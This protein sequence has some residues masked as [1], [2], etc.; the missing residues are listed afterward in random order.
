[1]KGAR[2]AV[3]DALTG[4]R[5]ENLVER[6]W[7]KDPSVWRAAPEQAG[8]IRDRLGWLTVYD[9][10]ASEATALRAFA[11]E[12]GSAGFGRAM[13]LGMGGSSLSAEVCR[14]VLGIAPGFV[15]VS[16]LDT[17]DPSAIARC[18]RACDP[19]RTL[20][21][22]ASKSGTT[23]ESCYLH[24][25]FFDRM[26]AL[27]GHPPGDHFVAITDPGT[28]LAQRAAEQGFRKVFLNPPDIGG[29]YSALSYFGMLP[30]ALMGADLDALLGGAAQMAAACRRSAPLEENPGAALGVTL[31][32]LAARGR[33]KLTLVLPE[34][35]AALGT[36]LE[37]L[38]AES[39][40]KE[41]RGI[42]PVDGEPIGLPGVYGADRVFVQLGEN[43]SAAEALRQLEAAGHPVVR[44]GA[45]NLGGEFFRWEFA[46]AVA[47]AILGVNP[48]DEPNVRESK[49]NTEQ[50]LE[51]F[52]ATG[53]LGAP[54]PASIGDLVPFLRQARPGDYVA[55]LA[56]VD[57]CAESA[58]A[59]GRIRRRIRDRYRVATSVAFGPRYLHSTG[60]M[61][62]GGPSTGLFLF[63][64][65]DD[66]IDLPIPGEPF[67]FG[68][69]KHA[70]AVGDIEALRRRARRVLHLHLE[71]LGTGLEAIATALG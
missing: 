57:P 5:A 47:G 40:G 70:Q 6:I 67:T 31:G 34:N 3:A 24:R 45:A 7:A 48:F 22:V 59:L 26:R 65:A 54:A 66:P 28:P 21:I 19:Q 38:V 27:L 46:M 15:D 8:A 43:A 35:L 63:L 42:F 39:T 71:D 10:M 55:L 36:W 11:A 17:T 68:I 49:E 51:R 1:M 44:A 60:Q 30:A 29:R 53:T 56:F 18:E 50:A 12:A 37:Q 52:R 14:R 4:A 69:V 20:F 62:K 41:G 61:H 13:V 33:D 23:A 58:A 32:A 2:A 25:Y 64:T 16:V 9:W